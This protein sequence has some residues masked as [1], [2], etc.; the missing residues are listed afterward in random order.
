MVL[1]SLLRS[2]K[3]WLALFGVVTAVVS[4]FF[5]IPQDIWLAI[6][7]LVGVLI[8]TIAIEDAALKSSGNFKQ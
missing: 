3:F 7:G 8:A 5:E 4:H 2:R 1:N 6:E